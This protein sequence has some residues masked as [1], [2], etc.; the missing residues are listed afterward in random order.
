MGVWNWILLTINI[1][2]AVGNI[3]YRRELSEIHT[4]LA[5]WHSA[6][7]AWVEETNKILEE[8]DERS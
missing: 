8:D 5:A 4:K 6:M 7:Q 2:G 3:I 1:F